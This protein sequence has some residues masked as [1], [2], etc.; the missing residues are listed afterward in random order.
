MRAF[1]A[2]LPFVAVVAGCGATAAPRAP[3]QID[4]AVSDSA[5]PRVGE[6]RVLARHVRLAPGPRTQARSVALAD[7]ASLLLWTDGD[8]EWG[9]RALGQAFDYDGRP[10]TSRFVLSSPAMDVLEAPAGVTADG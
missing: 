2:T 10:L 1:V 9:R 6:T 3:V 4:F 8:I 7:G 5:L